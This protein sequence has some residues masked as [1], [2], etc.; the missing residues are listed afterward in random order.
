MCP[1]HQET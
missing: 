1:G